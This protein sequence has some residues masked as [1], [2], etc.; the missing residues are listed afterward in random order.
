ME[1]YHLFEY[2]F[3]RWQPCKA[4]P[5]RYVAYKVSHFRW[6]M[7]AAPVGNTHGASCVDTSPRHEVEGGRSQYIK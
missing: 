2:D 7:S 3:V 1:D 4:I 6:V 5:H